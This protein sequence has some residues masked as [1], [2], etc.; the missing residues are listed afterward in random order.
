MHKMLPGQLGAPVLFLHTMSRIS[1][2]V[3]ALHLPDDSAA[4]PGGVGLE[5]KR[6]R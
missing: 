5:G 6:G 2:Q 4:V 3:V 1:V